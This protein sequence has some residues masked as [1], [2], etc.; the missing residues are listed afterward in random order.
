[1]EF[2]EEAKQL[3]IEGNVEKIMK[4]YTSSKQR[5][6]GDVLLH[7]GLFASGSGEC[8]VVDRVAKSLLP[9]HR[10]A[11]SKGETATPVRY[12]YYFLSLLLI[13]GSGQ[14]IHIYNMLIIVVTCRR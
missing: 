11:L 12:S 10:I 13:N 9:L 5:F 8:F 7:D 2:L 3:L 1:M 14:L 4:L 6:L